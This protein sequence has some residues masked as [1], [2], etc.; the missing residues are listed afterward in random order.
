M[1]IIKINAKKE[2]KVNL[3]KINCVQK[4]IDSYFH[5]EA[6]RGIVLTGNFDYNFEKQLSINYP[7]ILIAG[8]NS[9]NQLDTVHKFHIF[10]VNV[11][12]DLKKNLE[13]LKIS[14]WWN[15]NGFFIV[16]EEFANIRESKIV[17]DVLQTMWKM[18]IL[19]AIFIRFDLIN[20]VMYTFNPFTHRA[21]APWIKIKHEGHQLY[22]D[23]WTLY[24]H[25]DT[26]GKY[27]IIQIKFK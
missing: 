26:R 2:R 14:S 1:I 16:L 17:Y 10:I 12:P 27:I 6:Q 9:L 8:N 15:H 24:E 22:R 20:G 19:R 18:D 3:I 21:P 13:L 5:D 23:S 7:L 4:I 25:Q 11:E